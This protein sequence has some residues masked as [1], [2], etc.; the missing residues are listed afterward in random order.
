MTMSS[1]PQ[2]ALQSALAF[3]GEIE[4]SPRVCTIKEAAELLGVTPRT[5]KRW[6]AAGKMPERAKWYHQ[7]VYRVS[8]IEAMVAVRNGSAQP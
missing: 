6:Q 2:A 5:I 3:L 8:D 1:N 7:W 4:S